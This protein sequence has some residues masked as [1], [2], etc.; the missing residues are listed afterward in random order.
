MKKTSSPK[1]ATVE[2]QTESIKSTAKKKQLPYN[3]KASTPEDLE[4]LLIHIALQQQKILD[5]Q[6]VL[7]DLFVNVATTLETLQQ[8]IEGVMLDEHGNV[9]MSENSEEE[10]GEPATSKKPKPILN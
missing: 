4:K 7:E 5:R 8:N 10:S 1:N 9:L 3:R 6:K 2:K